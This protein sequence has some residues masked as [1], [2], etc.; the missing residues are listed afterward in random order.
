MSAQHQS[1][2]TAVVA[3]VPIGTFQSRTGGESTAEVG[4]YRPGGMA[5]QKTR[6]GLAEVGDVTI[7]R[8]WET[9]RDADLERRLRN[10]IG[11]PMIVN[12]QPLGDDGAVFGKPKTWTGTLSSVTGG[13]S[14]SDSNDGKM[15][16]LV[17]VATE[18][19]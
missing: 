6:R 10:Q 9:E 7:G 4:K 12:D 11:S 16:E 1:L 14:D 13:D 5:K 15:L 8:E 17:M 19:P 3:G 18:V 2:V